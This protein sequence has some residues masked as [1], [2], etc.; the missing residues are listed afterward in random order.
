MQLFTDRSAS[1][2]DKLQKTRFLR[3]SPPIIVPIINKMVTTSYLKGTMAKKQNYHGMSRTAEY[4]AWDSMIQRCHNANNVRYK[5]YGARGILVCDEWRDSFVNFYRDL[6]RRPDGYSLDRIDNELG[7][8]PENCRWTDIATQN[9]NTSRNIWIDHEDERICLKDFAALMGVSHIT[10]RSRI[11]VYGDDPHEAIE[12]IRK[13]ARRMNALKS[14]K[15]RIPRMKMTADEVRQVRAMFKHHSVTEI[16]DHFDRSKSAIENI[17][18][19]RS[20]Q[21]V[22]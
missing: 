4:Y 11:I 9:R 3:L 21:T 19:N 5:R 15:R 17:L 22:I 2:A 10:L 20:W 16:A 1:V 7:Y 13:Y 18:N 12:H 14:M 6:G 8:Y